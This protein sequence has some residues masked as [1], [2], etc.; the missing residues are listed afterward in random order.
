MENIVNPGESED[1]FSDKFKQ[2]FDKIDMSITKLNALIKLLK[3]TIQNYS[4][5]IK[6]K[7]IH[8]T[9]RLKNC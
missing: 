2:K 5:T 8:L 7:A 9:K 4:R 3:R 1:I 6:T